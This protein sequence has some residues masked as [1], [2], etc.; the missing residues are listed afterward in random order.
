MSD[1]GHLYLIRVTK[2]RIQRALHHQPLPGRCLVLRR[3][4]HRRRLGD[5]G[6]SRWTC[7]VCRL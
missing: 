4:L 2:G 3:L 7:L 1:T 5:R 6:V